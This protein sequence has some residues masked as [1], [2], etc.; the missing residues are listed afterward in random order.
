[1]DA[2]ATVFAVFSGAISVLSIIFAILTFTKNGRK[3]AN[4]NE[5]RLVSMEKDIQYIRLSV[6]GM[7]AKIHDHDMRLRKIE[8]VDPHSCG[9][10]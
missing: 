4:E 5:A 7:A 8:I 3:D 6:D 1:M 9:K 10:E 2:T